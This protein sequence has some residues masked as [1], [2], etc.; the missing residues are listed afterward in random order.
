MGR[1]MIDSGLG[2]SSSAGSS[3]SFS[4]FAIFHN[5]PLISALLAF[6]IAQTAKFIITW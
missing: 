3:S 5:Y 1:E 2:S 6:A 4:Q